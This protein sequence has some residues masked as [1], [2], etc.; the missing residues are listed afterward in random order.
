MVP[1][2]D[3]LGAGRG[4]T[5]MPVLFFLA[6]AMLYPFAVGPASGAAEQVR[7][8]A[9][10]QG[11]NGVHCGWSRKSMTSAPGRAIG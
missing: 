6:V 7:K 2:V 4:A 10:E 3:D 1:Q 9:P 5:L 11:D 8:I